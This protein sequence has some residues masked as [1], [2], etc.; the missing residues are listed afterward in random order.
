MTKE[1]RRY[2][3]AKR[4]VV[5]LQGTIDYHLGVLVRMSRH[6]S[7]EHSIRTV[8]SEARLMRHISWQSKTRGWL[9]DRRR[10]LRAAETVIRRAER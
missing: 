8:R 6:I 2:K 9:R 10:E 1:E 5:L 4:D 7:K 3:L